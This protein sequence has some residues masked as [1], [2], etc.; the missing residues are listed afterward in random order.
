MD[1]GAWKA[2]IHGVTRVR[3]NLVTK[4]PPPPISFYLQSPSGINNL[5]TYF[6]PSFCPYWFSTNLC[7][8][9][10]MILEAFTIM[11][12]VNILHLCFLNYC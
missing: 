1:R 5:I 2:T 9:R 7:L 4:P 10:L 3:Q 6:V 12:R 11:I 8:T